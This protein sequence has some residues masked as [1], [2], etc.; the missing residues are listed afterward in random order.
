[1]RGETTDTVHDA[2]TTIVTTYLLGDSFI[3][4]NKELQAV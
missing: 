4:T 2:H 1:L 3:I